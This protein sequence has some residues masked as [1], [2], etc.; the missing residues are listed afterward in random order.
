M[1]KALH[2]GS[3][4]GSLLKGCVCKRVCV[5]AC[6]RVCYPK[7]AATWAP[8]PRN[9]TPSLGR[10]VVSRIKQVLREEHG[11]VTFLPFKEFMTDGPRNQATNRHEGS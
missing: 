3:G 1:H 6:V 9:V 7:Y 11:S 5:W 10:Q 4:V 2:D 8:T